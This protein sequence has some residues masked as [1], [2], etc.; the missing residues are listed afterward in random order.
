M[1]PFQQSLPLG[2]S[3]TAGSPASPPSF[4]SNTPPPFQPWEPSTQAGPSVREGPEL[5]GSAGILQKTTLEGSWPCP[6]HVART[7]R[8]QSPFQDPGLSGLPGGPFGRGTRG[9][10]HRSHLELQLSPSP[11]SGVRGSPAES[12]S[13]RPWKGCSPCRGP[14]QGCMWSCV[15]QQRCMESLTPQCLRTQAYLKTRSSQKSSRHNEVTSGTAM[16]WG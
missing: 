9:N 7:M 12:R 1:T 15:P 10:G 3:S 8:S 2:G 6:R 4:T 5:P 11:A 13:D 14:S 16:Q